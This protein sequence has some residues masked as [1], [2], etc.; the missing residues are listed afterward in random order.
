MKRLLAIALVTIVVVSLLVGC[1]P[2]VYKDGTYTAVSDATNSGYMKA[3]VTIKGDK[4]TAVKLY[5]YN[6]LGM[7]KPSS[8]AHAEYHKVLSD[9]P[10]AMVQKNA[11]KVDI[12]AKATGSSTQSIQAV[13]R[14]MEKALAKPASS[15][16]YYDGT[17][18]QVSAADSKG[19]W[20]I[21]WVTVANDKIT[22]VLIH[23][24]TAA[25][26]KDADGNVVKDDDGKNVIKKDAAG[27]TVFER[28]T[29]AYAYA[30]YHEAR[31]AL[32]EAFVTKN[33]ADIDVFT[34]ATGT[35]TQS[36]EAVAKALTS[37]LRK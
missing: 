27:N 36:K 25:T 35:S 33:S 23:S 21:V 4:I 30:A 3:D 6:N 29:E 32:K 16:K 18:M 37:A 14:A 22:D 19:A 9:M 7:E 28:K 5:G 24:T 13:E 10:V 11:A 20:T 12:V 15:A 8:Y 26:E 34:G 2:A 1:K 31:T 17:Y